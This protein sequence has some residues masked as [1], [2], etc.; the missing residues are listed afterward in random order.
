MIELIKNIVKKKKFIVFDFDGV[1]LDSVE[2][3]TNAFAEIYSEYGS[4]IVSKVVEY[5][6]RNGGLSR[7]E[8][9]KYYHKFFLNHALSNKEIKILDHR[10]SDLVFKKIIFTSE[11]PG[12]FDFIDIQLNMGKLCIINSAT[13]QIEL[14]E[15]IK[16]R[17]LF[18]KFKFIFGSPSTKSE[19]LKKIK[20]KLDCDYSD[21][22]FFGDAFADI[23]AAY[24]VGVDFVGIGNENNVFS[25]SRHN[26]LFVSD[27]R[28]IID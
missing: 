20:G 9:F 7:F 21:I 27:F 25:E 4:E 18:D 28:K 16:E 10:F 3:K 24:E 6:K 2:I 26:P 12:A 13:P 8:K 23:K 22:V 5:H 15:I 19:N 1:V 11:I 14:R 17:D